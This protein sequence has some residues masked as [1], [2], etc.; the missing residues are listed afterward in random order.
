MHYRLLER[1][2]TYYILLIFWSTDVV[3]KNH[4]GNHGMHP[5]R[6]HR[7]VIQKRVFHSHRRRYDDDWWIV[8]LSRSLPKQD[9]QNR[10]NFGNTKYSDFRIPTSLSIEGMDPTPNVWDE[11]LR[12]ARKDESKRETNLVVVGLYFALFWFLRRLREELSQR[13]RLSPGTCRAAIFKKPNS[14]SY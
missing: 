14:L 13:S 1:K 9:N 11:F 6:L 4:K 10:P 3:V 12:A 7:S 5:N 8:C 2:R